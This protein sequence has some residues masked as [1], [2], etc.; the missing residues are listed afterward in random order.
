[1][2]SL[3]SVACRSRISDFYAEKYEDKGRLQVIVVI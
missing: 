2:T 3:D 1:M